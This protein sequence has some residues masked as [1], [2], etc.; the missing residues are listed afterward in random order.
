MPIGQLSPFSAV[1]DKAEPLL[2]QRWVSLRNGLGVPHNITIQTIESVVAFAEAELGALVLHGGAGLN[3]GLPLTQNQQAR[4][5]QIKEAEKKRVAALQLQKSQPPPAPA[6]VQTPTVSR[7]TGTI[8]GWAPACHHWAKGFCK[9]GVNCKF[10][11][12]GFDTTE[13]RCLYCG[14]KDHRGDACPNPGGGKDPSRDATWKAYR[15]RREEAAAAGKIGKGKNEKGS[16]KGKAGGGKGKAKGKKGD[17]GDKSGARAALDGET[18]RASAALQQGKFPRQAVGLDNWA[19]VHLVHQK[20]AA[21]ASTEFPDK[22]TLAHGQC[23]CRRE[24]GRKGVPRCVVPWQAEGDNIDL[25]PEGFLWERGCRIE[26]GDAQSILTP[27]GRSVALRLWGTLPYL[28]KDELNAVLDDLPDQSQPGRSG[29]AAEAPKAARV[30]RT[31]I[32]IGKIAD[33]LAQRV[34]KYLTAAEGGECYTS[35]T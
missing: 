15:E 9:E 24:I 10:A 16:S 21:D 32:R 29:Q 17:S 34:A 7:V 18:L 4:Q 8:S 25:F 5:H 28:M 35:C 22:L 3:T 26:R 13:G 12:H 14:S 31:G 33:G 1:F 2:H 20:P 19:N 11:H 27:T 30:A 23:G 6:P